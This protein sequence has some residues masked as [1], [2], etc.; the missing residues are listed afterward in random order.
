MPLYTFLVK[1]EKWQKF[2]LACVD[3][4]NQWVRPIKHDDGFTDRDIIMDNG[5][6]IDIFD[7]VDMKL[8]LPNPINHHTENKRFFPGNKLT[9]VKKLAEAERSKL[10]ADLVD[11]VC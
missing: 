8:G 3:E 9:F 11:L 2:C 7:V 10:L 1:S 4:N 5:K 6:T